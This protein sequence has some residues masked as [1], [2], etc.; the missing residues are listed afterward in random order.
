MSRV[1][2]TA[3]TL[4]PAP[5]V[6][7]ALRSAASDFFY[8]SWRLVPAN[9]FVAATVILVIVA[10]WAISFAVAIVLAPFVA[11]P[12][13]GLFRLTGFIARG[14]DAVLSDVW[15]AWRSTWRETIGLGAALTLASFVFTTNV[16]VGIAG[17]LGLSSFIA[18]MAGWGLVATWVYALLALPILMDPARVD[19][20]AQD[21]LRLAGL[22][23]IAFPLRLLGFGLLI[24]LF[25][26]VSTALFAAVVTVSLAFAA[27]VVCRYVL[28]AADRLSAR[29]G[30]AVPSALH[31]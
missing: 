28:P 24:A 13:A 26:A 2:P 10:W 17:G 21:R 18:V 12:V 25:L 23:A 31:D 3:G 20:R 19:T 4:P 16:L 11:F 29:S 7:A 8:N 1:E 5:R 30:L 27:L 22:L 9:A 14:R 6:G 15:S